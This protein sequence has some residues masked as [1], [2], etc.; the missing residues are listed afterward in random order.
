MMLFRVFANDNT[1]LTD[2][3]LLPDNF[4]SEKPRRSQI[5]R[6]LWFKEVVPPGIEYLMKNVKMRRR[7]DQV[8]RIR[9][10]E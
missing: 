8:V 6:D 1:K 9:R 3:F 2:L 5:L 7:K 4:G 10:G